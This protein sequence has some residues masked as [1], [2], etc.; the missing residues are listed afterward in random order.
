MAE[1]LLRGASLTNSDGAIFLFRAP[2]LPL[3]IPV[4]SVQ[5]ALQ[6]YEADP[7]LVLR[8]DAALGWS[9]R[10]NGV[11]SD[12]LYR[13]DD[14][15]ARTSDTPS[16]K[17]PNDR[18]ISLF[19]DS[20]MHGTGVPYSE[21]IG[22]YLQEASG[23]VLSVKNFAVG[24]YGM[25][26]ALL[27]WRAV[28]TH[29]P[30]RV[31]VFGFQAENVKRNG[32]IFR[33]FYTYESIDIPFSKPRFALSEGRLMAVNIPTLPPQQ[34]VAGLKGEL[35][36]SLRERDFFYNPTWYADSPLY[37]S[38]LIAFAVT[39]LF[40]NNKY[41]V[42]AREREIYDAQG[43][44]GTL[45]LSIIRAFRDEVE[46]TGARFVVAH[47]PRRIAVQAHLDGADLAYAELLAVLKKEF[48]V[49]DPLDRLT[50]VARQDGVTSLYTD[51]WHYS[52]RGASTVASVLTGAITRDAARVRE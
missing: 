31:V 44:L 46:A 26:Q 24:A 47:L 41:S 22:A 20:T 25:D 39:A 28:H 11:S 1:L 49:V 33:A 9:P 30:S 5:Q 29:T 12:G 34:V 13:Y 48:T 3:Q 16:P 52:G 7:T 32:S 37:R 15:G 6:V 38:R 21:T 2:C 8:Y 27:R 18:S 23:Q 4:H 14:V 17:L 43:E 36:P 35:H 42:A 40:M 50:Q 10:P 51:P 19:G 45:A